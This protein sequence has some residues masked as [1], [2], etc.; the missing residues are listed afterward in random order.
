[1]NSYQACKRD[2]TRTLEFKD[3]IKN[4]EPLLQAGYTFKIDAKTNKINGYLCL[5]N[6]WHAMTPED[7]QAAV[8]IV[9]QSDEPWR[10]ECTKILRNT[11]K[12]TLSMLPQMHT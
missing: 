4:I 11:Y 5:P 6:F 3:W 8:N 2:P 1:M 10:V 7:N 12:V 9:S